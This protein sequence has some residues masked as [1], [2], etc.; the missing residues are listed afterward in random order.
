MKSVSVLPNESVV[1]LLL[2]ILA[3][4]SRFDNLHKQ[5][6]HTEFHGISNRNPKYNLPSVYVTR[7]NET[8]CLTGM[9]SHF[10]LIL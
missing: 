2:D 7:V 4:D 1:I 5:F 9:Q 10:I 3:P 8:V 6:E